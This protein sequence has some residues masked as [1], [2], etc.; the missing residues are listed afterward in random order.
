MKAR[1]LRAVHRELARFM[2]ELTPEMGRCDRRQWALR[3]VRGLLLDGQRKSIEPMAQRLAAIDGSR[4]DYEQSLQQFVNQSPWDAR[5]I[6][7]RL[8]HWVARRA[9][10]GGFLIIDDTG[11]PKQGRYS[12]GVARQYS[13][14]LGKVGNCQVAVTLYYGE[15]TALGYGVDAELYLPEVWTSD[16]ARCVAAGVPDEVGH[17]AKW[18][19]A[20]EMLQRAKANGLDGTVLADSLFGSVTKFRQALDSE[21]WAYCV[22][23]DSTLKVI[24]A[25]ADL[26]PVPPRKRTG[27]PPTRPRKVRAGARSPSVRQWAEQHSDD[28]RQIT[29]RA[30]SKGRLS[31]RFAA[32]RVR[33]A[34][35]LS[36]G[37]TPLA[38]C[39]LLAEWPADE[40]APSKYSFS[41][42]PAATRLRKLVAVAKNRWMIEQNYQQMKGE[43]GLDHFEGRSWRG[44]HHHV[45][46]VFL[47][48]AFLQT[49]RRGRKRGPNAGRSRRPA[50]RCSKSCSAGRA[51][52]SRA[53]G[54]ST[55]GP[56]AQPAADRQGNNLTE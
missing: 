16:R 20:L 4:G 56:A 26:G 7:D 3:Y 10:R 45:T 15:A 40:D 51:S 5:P 28:F 1:E 55:T 21:D 48:W 18:Q 47:A 54:R 36:S 22:G 30:G 12:I 44:W 32:W 27:R 29:W 46:L 50:A 25:D 34:H 11:F 24:A 53:V 39:W 52:A 19:S 35:Q 23:V 37:R 38:P 17:R 8:T 33:P 41:N 42:L 49:Q 31:S 2:E 6:R 14:T 43:L 13:G 9:G